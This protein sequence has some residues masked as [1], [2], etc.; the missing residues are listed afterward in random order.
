MSPSNFEHEVRNA[1]LGVALEVKQIVESTKQILEA[2]SRMEKHLRR[3]KVAC[4]AC[5]PFVENI[6]KEK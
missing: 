5:M 1:S 3:M 4:E 6:E 2:L